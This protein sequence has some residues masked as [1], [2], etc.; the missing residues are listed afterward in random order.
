MKFIPFIAAALLALPFSFTQAGQLEEQIEVVQE[1]LSERH[2][3]YMLGVTKL[4]KEAGASF[5]PHLLADPDRLDELAGNG[6]E[7]LL[8]R[9]GPH[10]GRRRDAVG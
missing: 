3:Y 5:Q 4:L 8:G 7:H 9:G 2:I 6:H 1:Q 10:Q